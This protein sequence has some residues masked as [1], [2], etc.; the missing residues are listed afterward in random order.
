MAPVNLTRDSTP[1]DE[2]LDI[3]LPGGTYTY[4]ALFR[5]PLGDLR[6]ISWK[7][8]GRETLDHDVLR[9]LFM[10][11]SMLDSNFYG[12]SW[13]DHDLALELKIMERKV[14][15]HPYMNEAKPR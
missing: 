12:I 14:I 13:Q 1:L 7:Q 10:P 4:Y 5:R 8:I 15:R 9:E 6:P 2:K 3:R 11:Q